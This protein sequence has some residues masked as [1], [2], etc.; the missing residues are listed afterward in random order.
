MMKRPKKRKFLKICIQRQT[1]GG[2]EIGEG[3]QFMK[4][5]CTK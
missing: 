3:E 2:G 4:K 1:V 5:M